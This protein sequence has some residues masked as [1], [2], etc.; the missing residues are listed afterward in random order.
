[1][2]IRLQ[3][4]AAVL[5]ST[6]AV[7][8]QGP[9]S[10]QTRALEPA[11]GDFDRLN[12]TVAW[13]VYLPV[14]GRGDGIAIVQPID[15]QVFVQLKS[16]TLIVLQAHADA[17]TFR[18]PGDVLW[19]HKPERFSGVVVPV[20]VVQTEV[21]VIHGQ[22]L[23]ILDRVDGK[24]KYTEEMASTAAAGPA[25]DASTVYIPLTSRRIV[26]YSH[27]EKIPGYRARKPIEFPDPIRK[28]NLAIEP[29]DELSSPQ[30]RSPSLTLLETLRPPFKKAADSIDSSVSIAG[31]K[32]VFP[33][34]RAYD[35]NRSPSIALLHNLREVY[36]SSSKDSPTR[37]KYL[38]ELVSGG[39]LDDTPVLTS[40]PSDPSGDRLTTDTG[41]TILTARREAKGTNPISTEY[42]T[43]ARITAPLTSHGDLMYVATADS[44]FVALSTREIREPSMA[45][46]ALPRGKFTAGGA[47]EQ[48]PLI[49]E[50]SLYVVGERWGLIRLRRGT[51]EPMWRESLVD[52]RV[53]AKPLAAATRVLAANSS[54]VYA[55]NRQGKLLVID[56]RRG[57][58][59]SSIDVSGFNVPVMNEVN[60]RL[61]LA[62]NN[63][64]LICAHDK[65]LVKPELLL[66]QAAPKPVPE[67]DPKTDP[68]PK[69]D[70]A[71]KKDAGPKKD[72]APKDAGPKK[73]AAPKD[74]A[75]PK[76]G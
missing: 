52:G 50:D 1:M 71:P 62:A 25:A 61:Y 35:G 55:I 67:A 20:A 69:V 60:D 75:A 64:L 65:T 48:K 5:F 38:W 58:L 29:A 42:F 12:M 10:L 74:A 7:V 31:L 23:A 40:D 6:A 46:N 8:A 36:E 13:R 9:S 33:P 26:A 19:K 32:S 21:Y 18:K 57:L 54:Y 59:L 76:A 4:F 41:N 56:A 47:I 30:N 11:V 3:A 28:V 66:K 37:L 49:T 24:V 51:L 68:E 34:Y 44:N 53:R 2:S 27:V 17:R 45:Q 43:Q 72:A 39:K 15:D 73:D 22:R 70:P 16:G 14:E 63:G